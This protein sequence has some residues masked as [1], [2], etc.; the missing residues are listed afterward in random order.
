MAAISVDSGEESQELVARLG[1]SFPLLSDPQMRV[2]TAYGVAMQGQDIAVPSVFIVDKLRR[3]QW[4]Y[5]GET[6]ADRPTN[7]TLLGHIDELL[8]ADSR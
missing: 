4:R 6:Q 5:V 8:G 3:I 2:I 7:S 1:L